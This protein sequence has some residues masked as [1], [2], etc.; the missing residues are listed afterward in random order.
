MRLW[1]SPSHAHAGSTTAADYA[2]HRPDITDIAQ[3][4]VRLAAPADIPDSAPARQ[5][6]ARPARATAAAPYLLCGV[7]TGGSTQIQ[8]IVRQIDR[9]MRLWLA[10]WVTTLL[11]ERAVAALRGQEAKGHAFG[12]AVRIATRTRDTIRTTTHLTII[13]DVE[14]EW[15]EAAQVGA[16]GLW[17]LCDDAGPALTH[18]IDLGTGLVVASGLIHQQ[19]RWEYVASCLLLAQHRT[20]RL[21]IGRAASQRYGCSDAR[22]CGADD[23]IGAQHGWRALV[24]FNE[25]KNTASQTVLTSPQQ[26]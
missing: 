1:L 23:G 24:Q 26:T 10:F 15:R 3:P 13:A 25:V 17:D 7:D 18:G 5:S 20:R 8:V 22:G 2:P 16:T 9:A 6:S 21:A 14:V 11:P 19:D 4:P 12:A